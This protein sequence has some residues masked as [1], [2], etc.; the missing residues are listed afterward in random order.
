M[1]ERTDC[2]YFNVHLYLNCIGRKGMHMVG[3][4]GYVYTCVHVAI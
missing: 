2:N 4:C 3:V 1:Q